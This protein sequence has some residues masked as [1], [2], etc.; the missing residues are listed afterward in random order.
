MSLQPEFLQIGEDEYLEEPSDDYDTDVSIEDPCEEDCMLEEDPNLWI[1]R[2][3][4]AETESDLQ[5]IESTRANLLYGE[6]FDLL[7]HIRC[8][9]C[10]KIIGH[11]WKPYLRYT[12]EKFYKV[13]NIIGLL[14]LEEDEKEF[15]IEA[16]KTDPVQFQDILVE[17][18][19]KN[20]FDILSKKGKYLN[21]EIFEKLNLKRP[22]CRMN[23]MSP[24]HVPIHQSAFSE[25]NKT[26]TVSN[27]LLD[28]ETQHV[29]VSYE[30]IPEEGSSTEMPAEPTLLIP[31]IKPAPKSACS[32]VP[33]MKDV[34]VAVASLPIEEAEGEDL[35]AEFENAKIGDVETPPET[36]RH[37]VAVGKEFEVTRKPRRFRAR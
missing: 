5:R 21:R 18:D 2:T 22:C 37:I 31:K 19:V 11:L 13:E 8:H 35:L 23:L 28:A 9:Q 3:L 6:Q 24:I 1:K 4:E 12:H 25:E 14:D 27:T 20:D 29:E 7:P 34:A 26:T 30:S 16:S 10:G 17:L 32:I 33:S 36:T 15:L